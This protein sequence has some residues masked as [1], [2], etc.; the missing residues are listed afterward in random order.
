MT[1]S[2]HLKDIQREET[3]G[4]QARMGDLQRP[5]SRQ[6]RCEHSLPLPQYCQVPEYPSSRGRNRRDRWVERKQLAR[7]CPGLLALE[8]NQI[9][10]DFMVQNIQ[11]KKS[12]IFRGREKC[13]GKCA[14]DKMSKILCDSE[15]ACLLYSDSLL[16]SGLPCYLEIWQWR[17]QMN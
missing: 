6:C 7:L 8:N 3:E 1:F 16:S 2:L 13:W 14:Q 11:N 4:T 17:V 15:G 10:L 5:E 12:E 9:L